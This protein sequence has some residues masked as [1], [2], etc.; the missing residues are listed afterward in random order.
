VNEEKRGKVS[1]GE[2]WVCC[3][4]EASGDKSREEKQAG[5]SSLVPLLSKDKKG[6]VSQI[7]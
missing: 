2:G 4:S 7:T 6:T 5:Y 1:E 3:F